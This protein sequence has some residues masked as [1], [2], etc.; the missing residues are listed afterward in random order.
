SFFK[1]QCDVVALILAA[2]P[3]R[4][5]YVETFALNDAVLDLLPPELGLNL[6]G[7]AERDAASASAR[8]LSWK[9]ATPGL[10]I[11][12]RTSADAIVIEEPDAAQHYLTLKAFGDFNGDGI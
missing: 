8:G 7:D 4:V 11:T 12:K 3:S 2:K 10:K 9:Q 6:S 1:E 5:S